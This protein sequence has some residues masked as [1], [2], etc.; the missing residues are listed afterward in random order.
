MRSQRNAFDSCL[1]LSEGTGSSFE[2]GIMFSAETDVGV[3]YMIRGIMC[4]DVLGIQEY[5]V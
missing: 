4:L 2:E 1:V 3:R 5:R